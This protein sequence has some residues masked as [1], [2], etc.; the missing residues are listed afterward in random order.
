MASNIISIQKLSHLQFLST[1]LSPTLCL[2]VQ[3]KI[4]MLLRQTKSHL[5]ETSLL[6]PK[7]L[8]PTLTLPLQSV[9]HLIFQ[10]VLVVKT[11][12]FKKY[13]SDHFTSP[14]KTF[15]W[16]SISLRVKTRSLPW[17]PVSCPISPLCLFNLI[18]IN[19]LDPTKTVVAC[20]PFFIDE[21]ETQSWVT[22]LS[23]KR[24]HM[25]YKMG[26]QVTALLHYSTS[27]QNPEEPQKPVVLYT[28]KHGRWMWGWKQENSLNVWLRSH[29]P[30]R[31]DRQPW[32][33]NKGSPDGSHEPERYW[34]E[35]HRILERVWGGTPLLV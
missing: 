31:I 5:M 15:Q 14:L 8:Q 12:I 10:K 29:T 2:D 19:S 27:Q 21:T 32:S 24:Q 18:L 9:R 26:T 16:L 1:T 20:H 22:G 17:S 6:K 3:Q 33:R 23:L 13:K 30:T 28:P 11:S 35:G 4:K 25:V 7:S 34:T